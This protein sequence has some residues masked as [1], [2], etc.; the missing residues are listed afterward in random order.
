MQQ[1]VRRDFYEF[2]ALPYTRYQTRALFL[3]ANHAP[4]ETVKIA[5]RGVLDWVFTK[6]A[7]SGNLDRDHRPF[8]RRPEEAQLGQK[9]WWSS[10]MNPAITAASIFVGPVQHASEDLDLQFDRIEGDKAFLNPTKYPEL[11]AA[12]AYFG[13]ALVDAANTNYTLPAALADWLE[14]RFTDDAANRLTYVQGIRHHSATPDDALLFLQENSG[15]EI[16]SGNRN[17]T[18]VGGGSYA[19]PGYL[20]TPP[21]LGPEFPVGT[22]TNTYA[23]K[24]QLDKLWEGY[25]HVNPAMRSSGVDDPA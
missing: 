23:N 9:A 20:P 21:L 3:L 25:C 14:K 24:V 5:A 18:I 17:W 1:L 8:R 2:N 12:P 10:S 13:D 4:D 7:L 11:G 22:V 6:L 15:A 19:T 16:T